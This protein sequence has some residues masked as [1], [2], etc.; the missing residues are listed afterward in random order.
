[1]KN[2]I[3]FFLAALCLAAQAADPAAETLTGH[4]EPAKRT[5]AVFS[6][7]V[8][9]TGKSA[10]VSFSAGNPDGSGAAPDGDAEGTVNAKGDLEFKW[11]DTFDNAG[12]GTLHR[13][14]KLFQLSM[15]VS[16]AAEPR[17][18][19]FYGDM[20]LKRTSLKPQMSTR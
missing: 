19:A 4:F 3:P 2:L 8:M 1:M 6:L 13:N 10:K 17:A 7:D 20:T 18:L 5:K 16:K 14:G 15:K 11:T 9:Q 12:T